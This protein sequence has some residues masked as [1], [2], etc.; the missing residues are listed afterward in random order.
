[1]E[2]KVRDII[3]EDIEGNFYL[4]VDLTGAEPIRETDG[5][6]CSEERF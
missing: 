1:M 3:R 4:D 6:D 5:C 2:P